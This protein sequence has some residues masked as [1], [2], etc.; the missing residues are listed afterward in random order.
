M[1]GAGWAMG[2]AV[3]GLLYAHSISYLIMFSVAMEL[4]SIPL[5]FMVR[6]ES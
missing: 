4:V 2:G 1:Y 6:R 5:F 3:M